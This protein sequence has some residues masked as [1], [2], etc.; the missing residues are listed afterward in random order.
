[1]CSFLVQIVMLIIASTTLTSSLRPQHQGDSS[2]S[3]SIG[4]S[5]ITHGEC[6][7]LCPL[8]YEP[9]G[10]EAKY[11]CG[12]SLITN[13]HVL[14][15]AHC[16]HNKL[17]SAALHIPYLRVFIGIHDLKN[18][19]NQG[20]T[21]NKVT[22]AKLHPKWDHSD[23]RYDADIAVLKM[24][25]IV[26][27]SNFVQRISLPASN[28]VR[29]NVEGFVVGYGKSEL[30]VIHESK[31][32][33]I[34]IPITNSEK[35]YQSHAVFSEIKSV[36]SFCAGKVGEIPC[37]G[38]SGGSFY[39]F[40]K[41]TPVLVGVVS[42]G[43]IT[44]EGKCRDDVFA[45]FTN[46]E[47]FVDW[48]RREVGSGYLLANAESTA[49]DWKLNDAFC[50]YVIDDAYR[51]TLRGV[52]SPKNDVKITGIHGAHKDDKDDDDIVKIWIIEQEAKFIPEMS[53]IVSKFKNIHDLRIWTCGLKFIERSKL[54]IFAKKLRVLDFFNN[55]IEVIPDDAFADLLRL[56]ELKILNNRVKFLPENIFHNLKNLKYFFAE[57]NE[58]EE[59]PARLF[60]DTQIAVVSMKNNLLKRV[61]VDFRRL[62]NVNVIDFHQNTCI[63][64]CLGHY[65][66]KMSVAEMQKEIREK[67][68]KSDDAI[69][70]PAN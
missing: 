24:A 52:R 4:G 1:M 12:T 44:K 45:V 3:L 22:E 56:E 9:P 38:D 17:N 64:Q 57:N 16:I 42:V 48:I 50:E 8:F 23:Q 51:C 19:L 43:V 14:T 20:I 66:G 63:S 6:P 69:V 62:S 31:P 26:T 60:I 47:R 29:E 10:E 55:H 13:Q 28:L 11:F 65:C 68:T 41:K 70:F 15:A 25:N 67:C 39:L 37:N 61:F 21:I 5:Y 53:E 46:V 54:A 30:E 27:F 49:T 33:K 34:K 36:E 18:P 59:L 58:I 35:C 2:N 32:K 40:Q 7:W